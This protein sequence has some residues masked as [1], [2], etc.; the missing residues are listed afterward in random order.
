MTGAD[1]I[2]RA[3]ANYFESFRVV[4]AAMKDGDIWEKDGLLVTASGLPIAFLNLAFVTRRLGNPAA[5]IGEACAYYD[6]RG[7]PFVLRIRD[8]VSPE[9]ERAA[10]AAGLPYTDTM[11]GMVLSPMPDPAPPAP[12]TLEIHRVQDEAEL[13]G[14]AVVLAAG[15]DMPIEM[16]REFASP[17]ML[18]QPG[19]ELYLGYVEGEPVATS[20]LVCSDGVAGVVNVATLESYRRRGFGEALTWRAV[21]GGAAMGCDMAN[22][23][24]SQM[25]MPVYLKMGFQVVAGYKTFLRPGEGE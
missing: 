24:A 22:L 7:L 10:Q 20:G 3:D 23:Q 16:G 21:E 13:R 25:G 2:A 6:R 4:A 9:C 19:T 17:A 14:Y 12:N 15:F 5:L 1:V 11:P 8:G 18:E